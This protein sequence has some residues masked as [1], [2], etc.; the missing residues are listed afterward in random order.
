M[1]KKT[2]I[3]AIIFSLDAPRTTINRKY[4]YRKI[5]VKRDDNSDMTGHFHVTSSF[6][7]W[8]VIIAR[9]HFAV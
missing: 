4:H 6:R 2:I 1:T 3:S 5:C 9:E 8:N 7:K